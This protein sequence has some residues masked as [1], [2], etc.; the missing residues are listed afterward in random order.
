MMADNRLFIYHIKDIFRENEEYYLMAWFG[1][2]SLVT[3]PF[4]E[5]DISYNIFNLRRDILGQLNNL[6]KKSMTIDLLR[7]EVGVKLKTSLG[8][9]ALFTSIQKYT[10][11]EMS[12]HT[13][14]VEIPWEWVYFEEEGKFLC[15]LFPYGK[16]FLEKINLIPPPRKPI[17]SRIKRIEDQLKESVVLVLYDMGGS[18]GLRK[19]PYVKDEIDNLIRL[20]K[21][22]GILRKNILQI[23]GSKKE[24]ES[25]FMNII[26]T[27]RENL[28]IIHYAGHIKEESLFMTSGMIECKEIE[29]ATAHKKL[30]APLVF[31][32]G[33]F[34]GNIF[35]EWEQEKNLSTSFLISG[36]SGCIC[37]RRS[38]G[39]KTAH[40]FSRMFY[41]K[42]LS[43]DEDAPT[44]I[45]SVLQIAR[46]G[47]KMD[48]PTKDFSWLLYTLHG[49]PSYELFPRFDPKDLAMQAPTKESVNRISKFTV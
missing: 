24:A 5:A 7:D 20:F 12:I 48:C 17:S 49:D 11:Q 36:A 32:N 13:N 1:E 33:C 30:N 38:I 41:E 22:A 44:T 25:D 14:D 46:Q 6:M 18:E 3:S 43:K 21:N 16:V 4:Q 37:T 19:L 42:L 27:R 47:F 8:L 35:E 45:G 23:D 39:D 40:N 15:E 34:S 10:G 29:D 9:N 26:T 28:K 31:L 2:K